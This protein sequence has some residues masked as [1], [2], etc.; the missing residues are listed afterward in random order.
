LRRNCT[1]KPVREGKL[2]GKTRMTVR[3]GRR[4]RQ[5]LN[6]L[7]EKRGYLKLKEEAL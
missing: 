1:V 4:P 5:L 3:R 7:E 6:V 2:K